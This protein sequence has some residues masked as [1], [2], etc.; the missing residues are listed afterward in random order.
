MTA[1]L[2]QVEPDDDDDAFILCMNKIG[3]NR[4]F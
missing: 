4:F 2:L 1:S 3:D